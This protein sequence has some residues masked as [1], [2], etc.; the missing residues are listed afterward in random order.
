MWIALI[1]V[2]L[3]V[4][5][6]V[7]YLAIL[8]GR[9]TLRR[10]LEVAAPVESAFAAVVD[11]KSWPFWSPWLLHEPDARLTFSDDC[12]NEHG[13]YE[14]DGDLVGAGRLTHVRIDPNQ[15]IEQQLEFRRP[16]KSTSRIDWAFEAEITAQSQA[17]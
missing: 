6:G 16:Y 9:F 8:P 2:A 1:I 3:I 14:W 17:A 15:R 5:S 7:L 4:A 12:Q 11:L 10:S 13:Y